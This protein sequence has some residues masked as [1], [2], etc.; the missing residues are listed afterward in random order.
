MRKSLTNVLANISN[1]IHHCISTGDSTSLYVLV[2]ILELHIRL[3]LRKKVSP[4]CRQ[5]NSSY[6]K[7]NSC[8]WFYKYDMYNYDDI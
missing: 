6:R 1:R 3:R 2:S 4:K 7:T 5:V 8:V